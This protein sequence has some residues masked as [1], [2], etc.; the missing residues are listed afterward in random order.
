M[1]K[2]YIGIEIYIKQCPLKFMPGNTWL[3][4]E[5]D[6]KLLSYLVIF[7]I[8]SSDIPLVFHKSISSV[9]EMLMYFLPGID[10][11]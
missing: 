11:K 10:T 7:L 5:V 4:T 8:L 2:K 3:S 6:A 1:C 9:T